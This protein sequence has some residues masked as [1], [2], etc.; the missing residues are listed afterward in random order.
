MRNISQLCIYLH[1]YATSKEPIIKQIRTDT[2]KLI[3][4]KPLAHQYI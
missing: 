3:Q 4:A 2:H 1:A